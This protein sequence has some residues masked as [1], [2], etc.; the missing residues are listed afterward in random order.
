MDTKN[1]A[2][3]TRFTYKFRLKYTEVVAGRV[4][5]PWNGFKGRFITLVKLSSSHS[6]QVVV[7]W[8]LDKASSRLPLGVV[9]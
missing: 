5:V 6:C 7:V 1:Y 8:V 4:V 2:L 3:K 9:K